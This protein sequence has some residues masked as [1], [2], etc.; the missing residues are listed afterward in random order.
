MIRN[1]N[2]NE[3]DTDSPLHPVYPLK[4]GAVASLPGVSPDRRGQVLMALADHWPTKRS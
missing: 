1:R 2:R 3:A 4:M